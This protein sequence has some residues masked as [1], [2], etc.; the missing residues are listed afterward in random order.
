MEKALF[1]LI[2]TYKKVWKVKNRNR[3][4]KVEENP[5]KNKLIYKKMMREKIPKRYVKM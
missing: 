2:G 4:E 3:E 1:N 5:Q